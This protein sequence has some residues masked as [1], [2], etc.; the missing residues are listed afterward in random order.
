MSEPRT[1]K[2][3]FGSR[4]FVEDMKRAALQRSRAEPSGADLKLARDE[5]GFP[6]RTCIGNKARATYCCCVAFCGSADCTGADAEP[7]VN[8][9]G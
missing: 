5:M 9:A 7:P 1:G 8:R 6:C 2:P 3:Y 4:E